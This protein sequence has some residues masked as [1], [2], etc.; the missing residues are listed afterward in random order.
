MWRGPLLDWVAALLAL[1]EDTGAWPQELCRGETILLPKGGAS[2]PLDRRPITLLPILYRIWA[3][4]RAA[5]FRAW[6]QQTRVPTFG[7]WA[8]GH[9]AGG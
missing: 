8:Q 1:V 6:L 7:C 3:A 4:L 9:H 5:Q 2:D